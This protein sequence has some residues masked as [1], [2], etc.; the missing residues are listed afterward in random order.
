MGAKQRMKYNVHL[1]RHIVQVTI[2][3]VEA[4]NHYTA[5]AIAEGDYGEA[6]WE[7]DDFMQPEAET[8]TDEAGTV[9][10]NRSITQTGVKP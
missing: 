6:I 10:W 2:M 9:V 1:V 5:R 8:V 3:Q 4:S 7:D